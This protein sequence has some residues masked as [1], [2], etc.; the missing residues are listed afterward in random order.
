MR[1]KGFVALVILVL[2]AL[3]GCTPEEKV[4]AIPVVESPNRIVKDELI[5]AKDDAQYA[6]AIT[7]PHDYSA[8]A[9]YSDITYSKDAVSIA[10]VS[11]DNGTVVIRMK[12][13]GTSNLKIYSRTSYCTGHWLFFCTSR[14]S[15]ESI[16]Q[17]ETDGG[18]TYNMDTNG[19]GSEEE[20]SSSYRDYVFRNVPREAI[21]AFKITGLNFSVSGIKTSISD[22]EAEDIKYVDQLVANDN[23]KI[24]VRKLAWITNKYSTNDT[25]NRSLSEKMRKKLNSLSSI[26]AY[27]VALKELSPEVAGLTEVADDFVLLLFKSEVQPKNDTSSS[28][29]FIDKYSNASGRVLHV[30]FDH[31]VQVEQAH[32][33]TLLE[34]EFKSRKTW[35]FPLSQEQKEA[36]SESVAR[37][38]YSDTLRA[39]DHNDLTLFAACH[40]ALMSTEALK[41]TQARFSLEMDKEMKE[42]LSTKFAEVISA[43]RE[44]SNTLANQVQAMSQKL[45]D[46]LTTAMAKPAPNIEEEWQANQR[47]LWQQ[48]IFDDSHEKRK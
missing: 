48:K 40:K 21:R 8:H 33:A 29:K 45:G 6:K 34:D 7:S 28:V 31:A 19:F 26:A 39:K 1:S 25:I 47:F 3:S 36:A 15:S 11:W 32:I 27:S 12:P 5:L 42:F 37:K 23:E 10:S 44:A 38:Y 41:G 18:R 2:F 16:S 46:Q 30:A 20:M 14:G 17:I 9:V 24:N 35:I 22:E 13:S 43:N 4:G